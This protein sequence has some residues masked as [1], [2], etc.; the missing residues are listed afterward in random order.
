MIDLRLLQIT[1]SG[2]P[3]GGFAFS[4]GLESAAKLGLIRDLS[5]FRQYLK[6]YLSQIGN[7]EIPFVSDSFR[8]V[9][10]G[11]EHVEPLY[12]LFNAFMTIPT[13]RKASV[14]QGRSLL[15]AVRTAYPEVPVTDLTT[16]LDERR[17]SPHFAP[18]FGVCAN[19]TGLSLEDTLV[20]YC[21]MGLRDQSAAGVRLGLLG[22]QA[23]QRAL[24]QVISDVPGILASVADLHYDE[25]FKTCPVLDIA[26]AHHAQLYSRLFQS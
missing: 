5:A 6:N 18:T 20:G 12:K 23:A 3:L 16:W 21:Y 7:G 4:S 22:P 26:Q 13:L 15:S 11:W 8:L 2:F 17:L 14:T 10:S 1:D 19:L 24:R 9:Q 25:A